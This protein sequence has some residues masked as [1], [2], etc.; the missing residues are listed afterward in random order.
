MQNFAGLHDAGLSSST[1]SQPLTRSYLPDTVRPRFWG[2]QGG[3]TIEISFGDRGR[4]AH[5][6]CVFLG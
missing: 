4:R 6:E 1:D 2:N 3:H 5:A